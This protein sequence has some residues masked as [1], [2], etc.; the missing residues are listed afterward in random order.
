MKRRRIP[1]D[2]VLVTR[3]ALATG[4]PHLTAIVMEFTTVMAAASDVMIPITVGM[5]IQWIQ[6]ST[7]T[8]IAM[9]I[10]G[11]RA[12]RMTA[13]RLKIRRSFL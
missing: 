10:D 13:E 3:A 11:L 2:V 8:R 12:V 5:S 9:R 7:P 1:Q 4:A 6:M